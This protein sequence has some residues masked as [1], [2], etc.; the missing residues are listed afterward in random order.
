[1]KRDGKER[2][3]IA[4]L[5]E[6]WR[7]RRGTTIVFFLLRAIVIAVLVRSAMLGEYE[8]VLTCALTLVLFLLPSFLERSMRI[9]LP[10]TMEIIILLFI[11]STEI[12][13]EV[14]AWYVRVHGWDTVMHTL[15]GFLCAAIGFCIVGV[16]NRSSRV[17]IKL[18]PAYLALAAFCFS[19]TI[20]VL[21]EFFEFAMDW[22]FHTDMQKDTVIHAIYSVALD[23][24]GGNKV[25]AV[26]GIGDVIVNGASL[27]L[28]GYLDI[29]II[30]TMKD[31]FVNFIGAV[32]FSI[33]GYFAVKNAD[34]HGFAS[35]FIPV[36][37]P[38]EEPENAEERRT[39]PAD[40]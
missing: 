33:I 12:L 16:L 34:R 23:P 3:L 37:L 35:R 8:N 1:M 29:G 26:T 4:E 31:L 30:D 6:A 5:Q 25:A 27:G 17:D 18:S 9:D 24:A 38:E 20:G 28:G 21:W 11:F 22:F 14:S 32:V 15:N 19:M 36:V 10:D 7:K 39:A 40:E 13:G 2:K